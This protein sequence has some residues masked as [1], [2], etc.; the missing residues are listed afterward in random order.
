MAG[1]D[2]GGLV[3]V[4]IDATKAAEKLGYRSRFALYKAVSRHAIPHVR[5]GECLRFDPAELDRYIDLLKK[6][7]GKC[8]T[9]AQHVRL[10]RV[11]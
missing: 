1:T 10:R 11:G 9:C 6:R 2:G 4:L 5:I 8:P 3:S 7:D